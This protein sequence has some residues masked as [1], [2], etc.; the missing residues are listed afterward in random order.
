V[1]DQPRFPVTATPPKER[2]WYEFRRAITSLD[3]RH[4][5]ANSSAASTASVPDPT[6]NALAGTSMGA[7]PV[8]RSASST[9]GRIRYSVELWAI[10][11][12]CAS[13][14]STS[15]GTTCPEM[16]VTM[17][18][19]KSRYSRPAPSHTRDPSPRTSSIGSW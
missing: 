13:S 6:K 11:P 15:F 1:A 9:M 14:A 3:R 19:K 7:S 5:V 12:A 10:F 4:V 2:P 18:P 16:V 17:P 8:R